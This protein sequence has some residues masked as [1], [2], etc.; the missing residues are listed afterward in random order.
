MT[1]KGDTYK[2]HRKYLADD[3]FVE[4]LIRNV[5]FMNNNQLVARL[6]ITE[7]A[8]AFVC[9]ELSIPFV[10]EQQYPYIMDV[11]AEIP[12]DARIKP[13][14]KGIKLT[15]PALESGYVQITHNFSEESSRGKETYTVDPKAK[16]AE[17]V[18]VW[19]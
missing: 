9:K 16:Y 1:T 6:N 3:I 11:L 15:Y 5:P 17:L 8:L 18:D 4:R 12:E 14:A 19:K 2:R 10:R 13:W 7:V